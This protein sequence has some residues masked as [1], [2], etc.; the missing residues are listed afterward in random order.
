MTSPQVVKDASRANM[1]QRRLKAHAAS[2]RE[3]L[4]D[5]FPLTFTGPGRDKRPLKIGIGNDILLALPELAGASVAL[6]LADY[7]WGPTYCRNV[8]AGAER[9]GLDGQ[10]TGIVSEREAEHAK[11]RMRLFERAAT[12]QEKV[13]AND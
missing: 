1:K 11:R 13:S 2:V 9:I 4:V 8:V 10:V 12:Q 3:I 6:A 5:R 7:A